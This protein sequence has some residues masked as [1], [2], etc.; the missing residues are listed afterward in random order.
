MALLAAQQALKGFTLEG[1]DADV[2]IG[3]RI[4][5]RA[6]EEPI[7]QIELNA[8]IEGSIVV[9]KVCNAEDKNYGY[10][11]RRRVRGSDGGRRDRSPPR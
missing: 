2:Q 5:E 1:A 6:L 4:I 11:A 8:G 10:N 9:E 3:V 7:R